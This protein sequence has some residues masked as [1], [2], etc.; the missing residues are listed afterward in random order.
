MVGPHVAFWCQ[1]GFVIGGCQGGRDNI[2]M[3]QERGFRKGGQDHVAWS[4]LAD[5]CARCPEMDGITVNLML[6]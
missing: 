3:T 5:T 1:P 4:A 2:S 6:T